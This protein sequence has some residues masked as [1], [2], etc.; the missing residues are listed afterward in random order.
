MA[1]A[2][3]QWRCARTLAALT[4]SDNR[5]SGV[6]AHCHDTSMA[7]NALMHENVA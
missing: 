4:D 3:R 7:S 5:R 6:R 1:S 2:A